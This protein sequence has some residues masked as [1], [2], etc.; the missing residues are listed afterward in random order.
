MALPIT[1]CSR[2][3]RYAKTTG[4][5]SGQKGSLRGQG[6]REETVGGLLFTKT[7]NFG[8]DL[9]LQNLTWW[10][11]GPP[12]SIS[13]SA[14]QT[15]KF[16]RLQSHPIF[17]EA[18]QTEWREPFDIP[19]G[20]SDSLCKWFSPLPLLFY[21]CHQGSFSRSGCG[22]RIMKGRKGAGACGG[23]GGGGDF[24]PYYLCSFPSY[25]P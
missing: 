24:L 10:E 14:E 5:E 15:E 6:V 20:I 3:A 12:K 19:T 8:I 1:P 11:N 4:D 21:V 13:K 18:F 2:R 23:G 25:P 16:P 22:G 17:S 9:K 7:K